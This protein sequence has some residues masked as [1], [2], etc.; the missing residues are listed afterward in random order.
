MVLYILIMSRHVADVRSGSLER[1][2]K[3]GKISSARVPRQV[4]KFLREVLAAEG[5]TIRS[6]RESVG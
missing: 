5:I 2:W 6:C 1:L 4:M 3:L